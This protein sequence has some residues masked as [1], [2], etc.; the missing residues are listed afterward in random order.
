MFLGAALVFQGHA[1]V[2]HPVGPLTHLRIS[3]PREP[4][5]LVAKADGN[6]TRQPTLAGPP[7]LKLGDGRVALCCLVLPGAV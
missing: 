5:P 7:V 6:R 3:D 1:P 4:E 2:L